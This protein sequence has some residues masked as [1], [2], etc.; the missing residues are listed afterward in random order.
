MTVYQTATSTSD[1][2]MSRTNRL[3]GDA[4]LA[5]QQTKG[6]G[7]HGRLWESNRDD[8]MY[9]SLSLRPKRE[10]R[11]WPTLSFVAALSLLQALQT[12]IELPNAGLKWPNDIL[13]NGQKISGILLEAQQQEVFLGCGVNLKN[14]PVIESAKF[15]ATD[16]QAQ[17]GTLLNPVDLAK[18]FLECF[19]H[20]YQTWQHAGFS[21]HYDLYKTQLLFQGEQMSVTQG[22]TV[23]NGIMLGITRQGDLLLETEQGHIQAITTGDVNL[24]GHSDVTSN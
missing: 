24:I 7:R 10:V 11:E 18:S 5:H 2:L 12:R 9:L 4:V 22:Q 23:T 17:T 20:N 1:I 15:A 21:A 19:Y 14:A 3:E 16:I 8:G 13:V 6:R